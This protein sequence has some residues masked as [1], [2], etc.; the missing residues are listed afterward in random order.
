MA[1]N[2]AETSGRAKDQERQNL[3]L[4]TW[5]FPP[6][7]AVA[8]I[9]LGKMAHFLSAAGHRVRVVTADQPAEDRSLPVEIDRAAIKRTRYLDLDRRLTPV[10][11][12]RTDQGGTLSTPEPTWRR[13]ARKGRS[14]LGGL[15]RDIVLYPDRRI[16]WSFTLLPALFR[17][18][19]RERPDL[20][21]V[22]GPPF[23]SFISTAITAWWF[24]IPWIAEFRDRWVDD[25]YAV[26]PRWRTWIDQG[27]ERLL[28]K[29]AAGIVTVSDLWT[30]FYAGKYGL[31]TETV[32]NGFDP[33]DFDFEL[34]PTSEL[35][36]R[37]LHAGTIYPG[38]RDPGA[39]FEAIKRHDFRPDELRVQ[40][41]GH[42]LKTVED[43]AA[44]Y[45]VQAFVDLEDAVP[46][47]QAIEL[48]KRSDVLL[49]L[50]WND[51]ADEGN[52]PAKVFEY[53][54]TNR[55]ILGL[56]PVNGVP[57]RLVRERKAGLFSN[58]P[59]NIAR[60]L[61]QWI[62]EKRH[63]GRVAPP[64]S[65]A[66]LGLDRQGQYQRLGSFFQAVSVDDHQRRELERRKGTS[67]IAA[68][69]ES[70][71]FAE[72]EPSAFK[73]PTL[74][75]IIDTEADFDWHGPFSRHDHGTA[76]VL[77]QGRAQRLFDRFGIKPTYLIDY[78]VATDPAAC[79]VLREF[80]DQGKADIGIQLHP[81]TNPPFDE[82]L[83][84]RNSYP[85]S[86]SK[87]LQHAKIERLIQAVRTNI[88]IEPK[89]F[90]AGRYGFNDDTAALLETFGLD[91]DTSVVPFTDFSPVQGP[92]FQ[93][94]PHRPFWFG[95]DR[96]L[97]ELPVTRN[98]CGLLGQRFG[99]TLL[100]WVQSRLGLACHLPG[101]FARS[102]LLDRLTLTPEGMDLQDLK[103]LTRTL[104]R[105]GER[106]FTF[107]F[108][109]PSLAS[110]NTPYVKNDRELQA[111][112][113]RIE[114][115]LRFFTEELDGEGQSALRIRDRLLDLDPIR[116]TPSPA[117]PSFSRTT[118][119]TKNIIRKT[120]SSIG[121]NSLEGRS[122]G[123]AS[124]NDPPRLQKP[125]GS[126]A[127][128]TVRHVGRR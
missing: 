124:S 26:R 5:Y 33:K 60:Q 29:H 95:N 48:Q 42:E 74:A 81:W 31:P 46:Y 113:D 2:I 73:R 126:G 49:L 106:L 45:G 94:S 22:S 98:L 82:L 37:V 8:A 112:L 120:S 11:Q 109:S 14:L 110:G 92:N 111:F 50:Q 43:Q 103:R 4:V 65:T 79:A 119:T 97:L 19:W 1:D 44:R 35:P 28:V 121:P 100:P 3:L 40:F 15:Y 56:G 7:N 53:F 80:A 77:Y 21:L 118:L 90:K 102:G 91:I 20:I 30:H 115:Y 68:T 55:Q 108:H 57:A 13:L 12:R 117:L 128:A 64:A 83:S 39:L 47:R 34:E 9:R 101:V 62:E 104:I 24:D 84:A 75:V 96:R 71:H 32:M 63:H 41:Y 87:V 125:A 99:P 67:A 86:L 105:R 61:E 59:G 18:I 36:L 17:E 58:D 114:A 27:F 76:S 72:V 51:P 127:A 85:S 38:R 54:A 89:V 107:V 6:A 69:L 16:D 122:H 23:S 123:H 93:H 88:N 66:A 116:S 52:V 78:P 70:P 10:F 25:P